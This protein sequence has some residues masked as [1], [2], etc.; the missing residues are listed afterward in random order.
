MMETPCYGTVG[1]MACIF[2]LAAWFLVLF[3]EFS[4]VIVWD[5]C[6]LVEGWHSQQVIRGALNIRARARAIHELQRSLAAFDRFILV[7]DFDGLF[8]SWIFQP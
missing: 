4:A 3:I 8:G 6:T 1:E 2:A 5:K 7:E